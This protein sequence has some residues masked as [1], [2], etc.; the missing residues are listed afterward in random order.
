MFNIVDTGGGGEKN[1]MVV[2]KIFQVFNTMQPKQID[3]ISHIQL[4]AFHL[5]T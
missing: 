4:R 3:Y 2:P 1:L 5:Q